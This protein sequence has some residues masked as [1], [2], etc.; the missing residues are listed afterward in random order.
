MT[1]FTPY[2]LDAVVTTFAQYTDDPR[3]PPG[4]IFPNHGDQILSTAV[5]LLG[6]QSLYLHARRLYTLT[7]L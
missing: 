6:G 5:T 3:L 4:M 7:D 2:P 1:T